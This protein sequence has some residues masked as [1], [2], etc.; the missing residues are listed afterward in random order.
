MTD[1]QTLENL[2]HY[3]SGLTIYPSQ[4]RDI[5]KILDELLEKAS[6]RSVLLADTSGELV[7]SRGELNNNHRATLSSLIASDLAASHE[8]SHLSGEHDD[9]QMILREGKFSHIFITGAGSKLVLY[10][11]IAGKV[12]LGWARLALKQAAQ[13]LNEIIQ[14]EPDEKIEIAINVGREEIANQLGISLDLIW[15]E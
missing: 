5:E 3:R 8:I 2:F 12:P 14:A 6:A 11:Q 1:W 15:K 13:L 10:A 4:A 7:A 9:F